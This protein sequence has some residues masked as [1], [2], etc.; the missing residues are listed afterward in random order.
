MCEQFKQYVDRIKL[1]KKYGFDIYLSKKFILDKAKLGDESILEI[2]TGRGF[3]AAALL[4]NGKKFI[5]IDIDREVQRNARLCLKQ[6]GIDKNIT[7]K[8]MSAENLEYKDDAFDCVI[9]SNTIHHFEKPKKC[10]KE[11][12]RVARKK[13]VISDFNKMGAGLADRIHKTEGKDRHHM[14][15]MSIQEVKIFLKKSGIKVKT[16]SCMGE[17]TLIGEKGE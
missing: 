1:Y 5:S 6:M 2:G 3:M 16:Y 17:T 15:G 9:S 8:I 12:I 13:I 14:G 11:I 10:M 7:L 4:K